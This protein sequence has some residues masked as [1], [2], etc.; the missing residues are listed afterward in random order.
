[1][2]PFSILVLLGFHDERSPDDFLVLK[3]WLST[4]NPTPKSSSRA[5]SGRAMKRPGFRVEAL[6]RVYRI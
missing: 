1:M 6:Y 2:W 3:V 4:Q 5:R